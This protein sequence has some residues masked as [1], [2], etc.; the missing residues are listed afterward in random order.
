[1]HIEP[2]PSEHPL[3]E[4]FAPF[5]EEGSRIAELYHAS[6]T[7]TDGA[8]SDAIDKELAHLE[9]WVFRALAA[10]PAGSIEE[11]HLKLNAAKWLAENEWGDVLCEI[12][13][14]L[15]EDVKRLLPAHRA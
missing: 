12:V 4:F 2:T 9:S 1:M 3:L 14:G 6:D 11:L 5:P 8:A 15:V 13:P 10:R 7:A